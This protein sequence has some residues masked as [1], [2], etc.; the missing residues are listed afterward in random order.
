MIKLK[1]FVDVNLTSVKPS[2]NE[3][4]KTVV[5]IYGN[6]S[7]TKAVEDEVLNASNYKVKR[8]VFDSPAQL[9]INRFFDLGGA[10]LRVIC[11]KTTE[12]SSLDTVVTNN[13]AFITQIGKLD[14][15]QVAFVLREAQ[16]GNIS[17]GGTEYDSTGYHYEAFTPTSGTEVNGFAVLLESIKALSDENGTAFRKL[18]T[19][20]HYP[21]AVYT[22]DEITALTRDE[23]L[24]W[25]LCSSETDLA[26]VLAYLSKVTLDDPNTLNDYSFTEEPSCADMSNALNSDD[27]VWA[28]IKDFINV[29]VDLQKNGTI[30]NLG[31][32]TSAGFDLV[33][34]FESIYISQRIVN[35]ELELLRNKINLLNAKSLIHSAIIDVMEIYYN[36]GYLVQTRYTGPNIYKRVADKN[37]LILAKGEVITGGYKVSILPKVTEDLRAFPEVEIIINT[38]KGIRFIK[39]TGVVL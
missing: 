6:K 36:I 21:N 17:S 35:K 19:R 29:D 37:I 24:I 25:K 10:S 15:D 31:G 8:T 11:L 3:R 22:L 13:N 16:P 9:F 14:I 27:I 26:S 38:N 30:I 32:N 39:T 5:Y 33:Q 28:S 4:N 2:S 20:G 1:D 23:N 7:L 34:E 18:L 12:A